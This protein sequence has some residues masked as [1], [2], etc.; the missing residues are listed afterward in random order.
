MKPIFIVALLFSTCLVNA[1]P[2]IDDAEMKREPKPN[3]INPPCIGC[4]YQVG[5]ECV[6]DK[7][8]CGAV[9]K[10]EPKPNI[11]NPPCIGCYYQVG[12]EC[13]YDKFKCG[14]V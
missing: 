11:I 13:V 8:K 4:Y 6:Y 12:N 1:K 14:A 9:R 10:R 5:N 3:I 2:S 7:F